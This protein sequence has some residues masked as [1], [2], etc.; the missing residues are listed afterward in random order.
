MRIVITGGPCTGKT[1][2]LEEFAERGFTTVPEAARTV[3]KDWQ[4]RGL[5]ISA[6]SLPQLE[7]EILAR[8]LKQEKNLNGSAAFLDRGVPDIYGYCQVFRTPIPRGYCRALQGCRYDKVFILE[9]LKNYA[10]DS[11]RKE[12]AEISAKIHEELEKTYKALGYE[13][14]KVPLFEGKMQEAVARRA[15]YIIRKAMELVPV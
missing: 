4:E 10:K 1:T 3:R 5:A 11:V 14:I 8:Q 12:T 9:P 7:E 6:E 13:V 15:D 2:V